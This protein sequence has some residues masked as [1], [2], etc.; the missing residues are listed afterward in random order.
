MILLTARWRPLFS[1]LRSI[2]LP[3]LL[4]L[5][6]TFNGHSQPC[7]SECP[8]LFIPRTPSLAI[9]LHHNITITAS[10][11]VLPSFVRRPSR[12]SRFSNSSHSPRGSYTRLYHCARIKSSIWLAGDDFLLC[13]GRT[14]TERPWCAPV[15]IWFWGTPSSRCHHGPTWKFY[16][17]ERAVRRLITHSICLLTDH[18]CTSAP[19][20]LPGLHNRQ[21]S[22]HS[23]ALGILW[24]PDI[25]TPVRL[26]LNPSLPS[27]IARA[28][29]P[30]APPTY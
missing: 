15:L 8:P 30:R 21:K 23:R 11:A 26:I 17:S 25:L 2:C 12:C 3:E 16:Q 10:V 19:C 27:L 22:H 13:S 7:L 5:P 18:T 24:A 29:L 4:L 20:G 6:S 28:D 9:H 1:A 14:A